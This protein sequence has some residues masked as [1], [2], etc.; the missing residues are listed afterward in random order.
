[1]VNLEEKS[2]WEQDF[3]AKSMNYAVNR[4]MESNRLP[5]AG[6]TGHIAPSEVRQVPLRV[7]V[8]VE[9][10]SDFYYWLRRRLFVTRRALAGGA[11]EA[12][13]E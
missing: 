8:H 7:D 6:K 9:F 1:M 11:E 5:I 12:E 2:I 13:Q 3:Q 4:R 10:K